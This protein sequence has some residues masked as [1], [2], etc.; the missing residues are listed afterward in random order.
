MLTQ[1]QPGIDKGAFSSPPEVVQTL[2]LL[3]EPGQPT[4]VGQRTSTPQPQRRTQR[5]RVVGRIAVPGGLLDQPHGSQHGLSGGEH[6][7]LH[8]MALCGF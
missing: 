5:R 8:V 2:G 1:L 3:V 4:D 7:R 6:A